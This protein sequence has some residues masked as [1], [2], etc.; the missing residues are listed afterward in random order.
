[1]MGRVNAFKGWFWNVHSH[2]RA[3]EGLRY[4][5]KAPPLQAGP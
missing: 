2:M 1:M 3:A 5:K 4:M